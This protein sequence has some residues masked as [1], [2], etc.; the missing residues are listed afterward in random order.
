[1]FERN[2]ST[3]RLKKLQAADLKLEETLPPTKKPELAVQDEKLPGGGFNPYNS[4]GLAS[5]APRVAHPALARNQS[6]ATQPLTR[7]SLATK[8]ANA[9]K[10]KQEQPPKST[11]EKLK[12]SLKRDK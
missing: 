2:I 1:M 5:S 3:Q 10:Q 6:Q 11:W 8:Y 7:Q 9:A 12:S 4:G